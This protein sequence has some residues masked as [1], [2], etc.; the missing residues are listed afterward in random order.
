MSNGCVYEHRLV[1][2]NFL[3]RTLDSDEHVHHVNGDTTDNR[4][5]NL[6]VVRNAIHGRIT[7]LGR[8]VQTRC[9]RGHSLLEDGDVYTTKDGRRDC[10]VCRRIRR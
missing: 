2:E 4:I 9:K 5:E 10:R 6:V 8:P 3:G 1:M 7:A